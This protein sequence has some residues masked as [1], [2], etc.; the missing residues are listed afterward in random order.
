MIQP[1]WIA[2]LLCI[3][4]AASSSGFNSMQYL[5]A[6]CRCASW[7]LVF[8]ASV[9][10]HPSELCFAHRR[11]MGG[12]LF[13]SGE[14]VSCAVR[15]GDVDTGILLRA[16]VSVLAFLPC[17]APLSVREAGMCRSVN[18]TLFRNAPIFE[19]HGIHCNSTNV[20]GPPFSPRDS[21]SR[22]SVAQLSN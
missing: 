4:M 7:R 21:N 11:P 5:L 19:S 20:P 6:S 12:C 17:G 18:Q 13:V 15:Y 3:Y 8:S 14:R 2:C 16:L 9:L 1:S 10:T 22:C